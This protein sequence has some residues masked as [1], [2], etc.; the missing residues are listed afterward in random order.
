MGLVE[1]DLCKGYPTLLTTYTAASKLKEKI[2]H[3][4]ADKTP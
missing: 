1:G 2:R 3:I 4:I